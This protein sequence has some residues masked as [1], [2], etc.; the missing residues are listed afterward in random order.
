MLKFHERNFAHSVGDSVSFSI[1]VDSS[2]GVRPITLV[3]LSLYK[4]AQEISSAALSNEVWTNPKIDYCLNTLLLSH[5]E[6]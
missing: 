3:V 2:A 5:K 4:G 1:A 6:K